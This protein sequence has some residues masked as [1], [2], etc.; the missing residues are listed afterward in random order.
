MLITEMSLTQCQEFLS[1]SEFGRLGCTKDNQPF[2]VP[3]SFAYESDRLYGFTTLGRKVEWMRANPKVCVE[4]DEITTNSNWISVILN[5]RYQELPDTLRH[6][7]EHAHAWEL[8]T[9][10]TDWWANA[11]ATRQYTPLASVFYCIHVDTMTGHRAV[12]NPLS[13]Q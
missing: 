5:G 1:R 10:R 8:L 12:H 7:P 4:V 3:I 9:K 2:V 6:R 11:H 13:L